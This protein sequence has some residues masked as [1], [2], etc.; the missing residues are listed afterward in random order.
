[1]NIRMAKAAD[2][3][4]VNATIAAALDTWNLTERV[5]R[6]SLPLYR[7]QVHDLGYLQLLVATT[8]DSRIT[9]VAAAEQAD[10]A[11]TPDGLSALTLHGLYVSPDW[12]RKGVG[13]R[14]LERIETIARSEGAAG[15]LA[16]VR[17]EAVPFFEYCGFEILPVED[18][19]RDYPH[20]F[21]KRF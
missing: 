6:M 20:R 7:Y 14:L 2:L 19:A 8:V 4:S 3:A 10:A 17:P 1:M 5:K 13:S 21:W 18:H 15:L 9:G 11:D 16:K 12:H